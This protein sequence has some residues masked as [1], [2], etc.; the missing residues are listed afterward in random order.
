MFVTPL[1]FQSGK[2]RPRV[3]VR[4]YSHSNQLHRLF[5][6]LSSLS[7]SPLRTSSRMG[8]APLLSAATIIILVSSSRVVSNARTPRRRV[9]R[10]AGRARCPYP[11]GRRVGGRIPPTRDIRPVV[12]TSFLPVSN[13]EHPLFC[14][15]SS[16]AL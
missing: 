7:S 10:H 6:F 8:D 12:L 11:S 2:I 9:A 5:F 3:H 1:S 16:A 14:G 15:Y 4:I 13:L